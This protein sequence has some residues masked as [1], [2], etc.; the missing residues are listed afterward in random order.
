MANEVAGYGH[1]NYLTIIAIVLQITSTSFLA[2][3]LYSRFSRKSGKAGIDDA[4]LVLGWLFGTTL[5]VFAIFGSLYWGYNRHIFDVPVSQ[6]SHAAFSGWLIELF[7]ILATSLNKISVLLLYLRLINIFNNRNLLWAIR[8]CLAFVVMHM[9]VFTILPLTKCTPISAN[10]DMYDPAYTKSYTCISDTVTWPVAAAFSAVTDLAAVIIPLVILSGLRK[11]MKQKIGLYS[12]FAFGF[13]VVGAG[14]ART[15]L[16]TRLVD[17]KVDFTWIGGLAILASLIEYHLAL[18]CTCAPSLRH[19]FL[20][21]SH[22]IA[23]RT[24]GITEK[25]RTVETSESQRAFTCPSLSDID[26]SGLEPGLGGPRAMSPFVSVDY[27]CGQ[28][29]IPIHLDLTPQSPMTFP[30]SIWKSD[31]PNTF[32]RTGLRNSGLSWSG[33]GT[34]ILDPEPGHSVT[35]RRSI[36]DEVPELPAIFRPLV[37]PTTPSNPKSLSH[38]SAITQPEPALSP[39]LSEKQWEWSLVE[40]FKI[41]NIFPTVAEE[42]ESKHILQG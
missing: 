26:T 10:W 13:L 38:Q 16:V 3:R 41:E 25:P 5:T 42:G 23:A 14:I 8:A 24:S 27:E 29:G 19:I 18:T 9:L 32:E 21:M 36:Q 39:G 11:P 17:T 20:D 12:V 34:S 2:L 22:A 7:F 35:S 6:Y 15:V 31:T 1:H 33:P 4:F 28:P 30:S 37:T 40:E